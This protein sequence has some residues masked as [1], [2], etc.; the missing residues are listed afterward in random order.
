MKT[1]YGFRKFS[2]GNKL[3]AY[4][5]KGCKKGQVAIVSFYK[6]GDGF[7]ME[8]DDLAESIQVYKATKNRDIYFVNWPI[9]DKK[10]RVWHKKEQV[11]ESKDDLQSFLNGY[12]FDEK[13]I[14]SFF[15]SG[16]DTE[17]ARKFINKFNY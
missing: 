2:D 5:P 14:N 9:F 16:F 13:G 12:F 11:F 7:F 8:S 1:M 10:K 6:N 15:V 17:D 4:Q 3:A